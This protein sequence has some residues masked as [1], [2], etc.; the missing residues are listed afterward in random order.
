MKTNQFTAQVRQIPCMN[1]SFCISSVGVKIG[2]TEIVIR[3]SYNGTGMPLV[4]LNRKL[5][6]ATSVILENNFSFQKA[7]PKVYEIAKPG[8]ILL[9]VKAWQDYLSFELTSASQWCIVGSGICS[10]CDS[11]VVN[12]FTN[13]TGTMYWGGS[14]SESIIINILHS[15]WQVSAIDSLFI[16]GYTSY[17]ERREITSNGYA[18]SFNGTTASTGILNAFVK[19][20]TIQ[21]FVKVHSSGGTILSY[22]NKFTFALVNDVRVKIFLGGASYDM[23]ITLPSGTWVLVSIAY[24]AST[25]KYTGCTYCSVF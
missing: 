20:F 23:G 1:A 14:I 5:T 7:S 8:R 17:K 25:G 15:Q 9:R 2:S 10:S 18:L 13:S 16:F 3:A 6:D 22:S 19:D 24:R 21:L 11:N 4:W 12:D